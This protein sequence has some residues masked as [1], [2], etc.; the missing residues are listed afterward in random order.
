MEIFPFL[1]IL[2][3]LLI[4]RIPIIIATGIT[5]IIY[6]LYVG[7]LPLSFMAVVA[8]QAMDR[9]VL[10]AVP[11]F[12]L[13]GAIMSVGGMAKYLLELADEIVGS[14]PGGMGLT[15]I[16]SC[17]FIADLTGS[18]PVTV[19]AVGSIMIPAM[20]ARGY[21]EGFSCAVSACAGSLGIVIP[22]SNPMIIYGISGNV[23]IGELFLAGFIPGII[24]AISMMIPAYFIARSKGWKGRSQRWSFKRIMASAWRAKFALMVPVI[25][26]GGIYGGIFTPT[27][28]AAVACLYS[29]I[30]GRYVYRD[31]TYRDFP[32]ILKRAIIITG[33]MMPI[34]AFTTIFGQ[35]ITLQGAP[36]RLAAFATQNVDSLWKLL[37]IINIFLLFVGCF[38]EAIA[39]IV[40]LTPLLLPMVTR[41]GMDPVHFGVVM[42]VNLAIGFLTP[43]VGVNLFT[44]QTISGVQNVVIF[45]AAIP[46][47]CS[48]IVALAMITYIPWLSLFLPHLLY[49]K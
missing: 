9:F 45:K 24:L 35:I 10:L 29:F 40:L 5:S 1:L 33:T 30:I 22:P 26:L 42:I 6:M 34:V 7:N 11:L 28:S 13:A 49:G 31:F 17:V 44:A 47:I 8:F 46:I 38:M 21:G 20:I 37:I 16:L 43:P 41:F 25:I 2:L 12:I 19:A 27:E 18:G 48:M 4:I 36:V 39:G 3:L 32:K 15:T 23:S 14:L